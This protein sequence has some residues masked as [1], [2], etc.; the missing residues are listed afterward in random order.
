MV[1]S[2]FVAR[3]MAIM[4]F[5][6]GFKASDHNITILVNDYRKDWNAKELFEDYR[7]NCAAKYHLDYIVK[8]RKCTAIGPKGETPKDRSKAC[9][10]PWVYG[11]QLLVCQYLTEE[12]WF[13]TLPVYKREYRLLRDHRFKSIGV[14]GDDLWWVVILAQ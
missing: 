5:C 3:Y 14:A 4:L 7:L 6:L 1:G 9:G 12:S 11:E 10:Y 8:E 2:M 13:D